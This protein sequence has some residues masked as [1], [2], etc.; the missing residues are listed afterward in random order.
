M[1][2]TLNQVENSLGCQIACLFCVSL[3]E[4]KRLTFIMNPVLSAS[5][6]YAPYF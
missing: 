6:V 2:I 5:F 4:L 1:A 3:H